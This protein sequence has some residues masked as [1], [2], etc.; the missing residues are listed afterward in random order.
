VHVQGQLCVCAE[1]LAAGR[2]NKI[3]PPNRKGIRL[4]FLNQDADSRG[5]AGRQKPRSSLAPFSTRLKGRVWGGGCYCGN[6]TEFGDASG[7]PGKSSLFFLTQQSSLESDYL[8][9]GYNARQS[10]AL[11]VVSGALS[12]ALENPKERMIFVPGRTD[13]RSRS[14]R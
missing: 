8:E 14:P 1:A 4:I 2:Y 9:I 10:T 11:L 6:A 3:A 5:V 13:N 7:S 12:M